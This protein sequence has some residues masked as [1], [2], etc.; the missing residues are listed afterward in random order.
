MKYPVI[1]VL[2][3]L[4]TGIACNSSNSKNAESAK[5]IVTTQDSISTIRNHDDTVFVNDR[6]AVLY[7]PD[8]LQIEKAKKETGEDTFYI[9]TDDYLYYMNKVE[10]FLDSQKVKILQVKTEKYLLFRSPTELRLVK[11]DTL[12]DLWGVFLFNPSKGIRK[13]DIMSIE[14]EY[15][16]FM[17]Q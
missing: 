1:P 7:E 12:Q 6:C 14:T 10:E 17:K 11:K 2:F 3:F 15:D 16:D 13:A 4:V 8:S 9:G 5:I